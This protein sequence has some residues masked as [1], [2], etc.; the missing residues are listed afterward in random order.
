MTSPLAS[1]SFDEVHI[2]TVSIDEFIAEILPP[3]DPIVEFNTFLHENLDK[4][5]VTKN[6]RLWG[7]STKNPSQVRGRRTSAYKSLALCTKKLSKVV[8]GPVPS[9][10]FRNNDAS[11]W[12]LHKREDTALPDSYFIDEKISNVNSRGTR[13]W[14]AVKVENG[15]VIGDPVALKDCWVDSH[16]EREGNINARI[17]S[18]ATLE[19]PTRILPLSLMTVLCHGDVLVSGTKD[20]TRILRSHESGPSHSRGTNDNREHQSSPAHQIHYRIVFQEIGSDLD[21]A[22]S[23]WVIFRALMDAAYGLMAMHVSGWVHG[24]ISP[25]NIF[26]YED[27]AKI[28]D[29]EHATREGERSEHDGMATEYFASSEVRLHNYIFRSESLERSASIFFPAETSPAKFVYNPLHDLESLWWIAVY[30]LVAKKVVSDDSTSGQTP[31]ELQGQRQLASDLFWEKGK[32]SFALKSSTYFSRELHNLHPS[33]RAI[34]SLV[35]DLRRSLVRAYLNAERD[36]TALPSDFDIAQNL[37][38][39]F[40]QGFCGIAKVLEDN[41][42]E[43]C[44][45]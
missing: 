21:G 29:L 5:P 6:N 18:S 10:V 35:D 26:S 9:T 25:G 40:G 23:L 12:D 34:A 17:R 22:T 14:K 4:L 37:H 43:I 3:I 44:P 42:I 15:T 13:V 27:W 38:I 11:V 16:R 24:D 32:R 45:L 19:V 31:E 36:I 7:Y 2:D 20:S 30:V 33:L 39:E 28:G 1:A 41:D 8:E